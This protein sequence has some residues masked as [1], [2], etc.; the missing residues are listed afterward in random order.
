[1]T[2]AFSWGLGAQA[3]DAVCSAGAFVGVLDITR[4]DLAT[5]DL[6]LPSGARGQLPVNVRLAGSNVS[7]SSVS[8][9][10]TAVGVMTTFSVEPSISFATGHSAID[11][12]RGQSG[13][14]SCSVSVVQCCRVS[15]TCGHR[16]QYF[17]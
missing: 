15:F 7:L 8:V 4:H 2:G 9:Y 12:S 13:W 14:A 10:V 3:V 5:C 6:D 17:C 1:M 16:R 11:L